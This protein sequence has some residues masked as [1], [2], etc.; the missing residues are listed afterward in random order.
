MTVEKA[1]ETDGG[2]NEPL[3]ETVWEEVR[4]DETVSSY[5]RIAEISLY[6]EKTWTVTRPFPIEEALLLV[7]EE[8]R[9]ELFVC[10]LEIDISLGIQHGAI[11]S[12]EDYIR[13]FP[14]WES[15]IDTVVSQFDTQTIT[16]YGRLGKRI[17]HY[18]I[19]D[20]LGKGGMGIVYKAWDE[21]FQRTV[22]IKYLLPQWKQQPQSIELFRRE[23]ALLG[24]LH[25]TPFIQAYDTGEDGNFQY[26]VMEYA[27]GVDLAKHVKNNGPMA[28]LEAAEYIRQIAEGLREVHALGIIHRDLK[29]E[30][31]ILSSDGTIRILDLGLGT[32]QQASANKEASE[33]AGRLQAMSFDSTTGSQAAKRTVVGTP[34]YLAPEAFLTPDEIGAPSDIFS[35]GGTFFY[36]LSGILPIRWRNPLA[37]TIKKVVPLK[38]YFASNNIYLPAEVLGILEKMLAMDPEKRYQSA[39]EVCAELETLIER[40]QPR[41][42]YVR[43][44]R[45]LQTAGVVTLVAL[46]LGAYHFYASTQKGVKAYR[47]VQELITAGE[48]SQALALLVDV[49][50]EEIPRKLR[51]EFLLCRG[52]LYLE[53]A[54]DKEYLQ[55]ALND[56]ASICEGNPENLEALY[57]RIDTTLALEHYDVAEKL[58]ISACKEFPRCNQFFFLDAKGRVERSLAGDISLEE[59]RQEMLVA[60]DI[61]TELLS[62]KNC[63][64]DAL[65]WRARAYSYLQHLDFA[66]GDLEDF[67]KKNK[68]YPPAWLLRADIFLAEEDWTAALN[69]LDFCERR[70]PTFSQLEWAGLFLKQAQCHFFLNHNEQCVHYCNRAAEV[71]GNL[72]IQL[73]H[74]RGVTAFR[75][76][77]WRIALGDLRALLQKENE[78]SYL[79]TKQE[80]TDFQVMLA[81][82]LLQLGKE[83]DFPESERKKSLQ[84]SLAMISSVIEQNPSWHT[85]KVLGEEWTIYEIRYQVYMLL[86]DEEKARADSERLFDLMQEDV[87]DDASV[88]ESTGFVVAPE[89]ENQA[90]NTVDMENLRTSEE[91]ETTGTQEEAETTGMS[92]DV[93]VSGMSEE[94]ADEEKPVEVREEGTILE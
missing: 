47:S 6:F 70:K 36:L 25:R 41:P 20:V 38:E 83:K 90:E 88:M 17:G 50:E 18:L 35:L 33:V 31:V 39:G 82:S 1:H 13:R 65:Y 27:D 16:G 8:L 45:L 66:L 86:G 4:L 49:S 79:F 68:D 91:S 87:A 46:A 52:G 77:M 58:V 37:V 74:W 10:V 28:F 73:L 85:F 3:L 93:G 59:R 55:Y 64:N 71:L 43:W 63:V 14:Q 42:W 24:Q 54:R 67:F 94:V 92:E 80:Q 53:L 23:I 72:P 30:N 22:A 76:G 2:E 78:L 48:K 51:E 61:L 57:Q 32:F 29:P 19:Q 44:K 60:V 34:A 40:Y 89:E 7:E 12:R 84:D 15:Q 11:L 26:L 56:F 81:F 21:A 9:E 75:A 5:S 62:R 69:D